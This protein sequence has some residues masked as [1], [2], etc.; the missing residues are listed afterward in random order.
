MLLL[1][2]FMAI[3]HCKKLNF[4][5]SKYVSRSA[6]LD[7]SAS[8]PEKGNVYFGVPLFTYSELLE[9]TDNFNESKE[10]GDGGFGTVYYG[11]A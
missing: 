4:G 8:D 10:L 9:A 2:A 7:H 11:K 1:V 3:W 6:S 5:H